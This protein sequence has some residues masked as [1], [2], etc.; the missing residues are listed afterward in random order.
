M[1]VTKFYE[2]VNKARK[3]RAYPARVDSNN[4]AKLMRYKDPFDNLI[5]AIL[6]QAAV[7]LDHDTYKE[8]NR[9]SDAKEFLN[10][11]YAHEMW[12]YLKTRPR[13]DD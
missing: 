10:S 6:L 12:E 9:R 2:T 3:A 4:R 8:Y 13:V 7:D 5:Y 1:S 11:E